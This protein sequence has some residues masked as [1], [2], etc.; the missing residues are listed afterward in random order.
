MPET[1][2]PPYPTVSQDRSR[3]PHLPLVCR[4]RLQSRR[5][6]LELATFVLARHVLL[7]EGETGC[8]RVVFMR[9]C[10]RIPRCLY[11]GGAVDEAECEAFFAARREVLLSKDEEPLTPLPQEV[12]DR[13]QA[14]LR[15]KRGLPDGPRVAP[16]I[17]G[18]TTG[19]KLSRP[20]RLKAVEGAADHGKAAAA[21]KGIVDLIL[22]VE[23]A[24]ERAETANA[25]ANNPANA[26]VKKDRKAYMAEFMRRKRAKAKEGK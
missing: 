20:A 25:T 22:P 10:D 5:V 1:R 15:G 9:V 24:N 3:G 8:V 16:S 19:D 13:W 26:R 18:V 17:A 21:A 23:A 7:L 4:A 6:L 11:M 14:Y 2:K 12:S